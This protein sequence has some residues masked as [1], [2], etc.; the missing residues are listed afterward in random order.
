[1]SVKFIW[2]DDYSV[3]D[4][5]IDKQHQ[6]LFELGNQ[7]NDAKLG[8]EKEYMNKLFSYAKFH[9]EHEEKHMK[10]IGYPGLFQHIEL[11]NNL[12]AELHS[13][14]NI[15]FKR[16][17]DLFVFKEFVYFWIIDH[18]MR[19]DKKYAEFVKKK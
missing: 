1:M 13:Y 16:D 11:H 3:G 9:F 19:Q 18:I 7:L 10:A 4:E 6:F 17:D 5:E 8:E 12:I 14:S 15:T 2:R